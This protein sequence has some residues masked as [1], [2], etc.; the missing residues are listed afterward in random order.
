[1]LLKHQ[2][3]LKTPYIASQDIQFAKVNNGKIDFSKQTSRM[4]KIFT[5]R[6]KGQSLLDL[7]QKYL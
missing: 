3:A 2:M 6:S 5:D 1:M 7:N 4:Q